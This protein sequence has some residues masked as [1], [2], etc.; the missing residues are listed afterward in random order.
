MGSRHTGNAST[1]MISVRPNCIALYSLPPDTKVRSESQKQTEKHLEDNSH[2]G[3]VSKKS[4]KRVKNAIDW[5]LHFASLKTYYNRKVKKHVSFKLSFTTLTLSSSQIHSDNVIKEKLLNSILGWMRTEYEV[6]KYL[7]RAEAQVN[8]NIHFHIITDKFIPWKI[9]QQQWNKTQAKLGYIHRFKNKHGN[10]MP[11]STDI[12]EVRN[13]KNISMYLSEY[14]AKQTKGNLYTPCK[15]V[16]GKLMPA[17]NPKDAKIE[18]TP[19]L[20]KNKKGKWIKRHSVRI[21]FGCQ[22]NLSESLSKMKSA[23]YEHDSAMGR[24]ILEIKEAFP[25]RVIKYDY[26]TCIY[27]SVSEWKKV[28]KKY[29]WTIFYH[30]CLYLRGEIAM[31]LFD[32]IKADFEGLKPM[33][34]APFVSKNAVFS[35][36]SLILS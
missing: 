8:G 26:V 2:K 10:K 25:K 22:W 6:K 14:C 29:L 1:P 11:N 18:D 36:E 27:V 12:H 13:I 24:D 35:Q 4:E 34:D 7:W 15:W 23:R 30:Y 33:P 21:V 19:V 32:Q 31:P 5:M 17:D 9:L 28:T 3:L 20:I 16:S